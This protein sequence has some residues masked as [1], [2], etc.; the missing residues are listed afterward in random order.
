[1]NTN[2]NSHEPLVERA[3]IGFDLASGHHLANCEPCQQERE[4]VQEALNLFRAAQR[5]SANRPEIFWEQQAARIRAARNEQ[6]KRSRIA[7]SLTPGLAVLLLLG[8]TLV[9][10]TPKVDP[11]PTSISAAAVQQVS[12]QELLMEV[13]RAVQSGTPL[14]L[15]PATLMVEEDADS[16]PMNSQN[17]H[18]E[19]RTHE[20]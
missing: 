12:D 13:E 18:K 17:A 4:R 6:M 2:E 9:A 1:M 7:P 14:S 8:I 19:L 11:A 10:R 15:G 16:R 5:E 3:L 20:D